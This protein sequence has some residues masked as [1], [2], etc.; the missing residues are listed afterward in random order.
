[1]VEFRS[2][3]SKSSRWH[4]QKNCYVSYVFQALFHLAEL[5][6]YQTHSFSHRGTPHY[7]LCLNR[8]CECNEEF[9]VT[10]AS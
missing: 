6:Q 10:E 9:R 2:H 1:M 8:F 5:L 4:H 3:K 7:L